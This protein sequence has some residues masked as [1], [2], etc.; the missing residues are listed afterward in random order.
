MSKSLDRE[1]RILIIAGKT[2]ATSLEALLR[3]AGWVRLQSV[4]DSARAAQAFREDQPDLVLIQY[5]LGQLD[6]VGVMRQLRALATPEELLPFV[7]LTGADGTAQRRAALAAGAEDVLSPPVD[8]GELV[9]RLCG[10]LQLRSHARRARRRVEAA[11]ARAERAD[12]EMARRLALMA[13]YRGT[14]DEAAPASLGMLAATIA[15]ELG[16]PAE[17]VR[18]IRHAAPL[19]DVG[20]IA[21]PH[22]LA[23][24]GLLSLAEL[25]EL[26]THTSIGAQMLSASESPILAMAEEIALFHHENWDGTGY[27]PGLGGESIPLSARIVA[28]A[29]TFDA[30]RRERSYNP[31]HT[32]EETLAWIDSQAGRKFDPAVVEAFRRVRLRAEPLPLL[33]A[34]G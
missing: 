24:Q 2:A 22:I 7:F 27:T 32:E 1:H 3:Q 25:D 14:L 8:A 19:H 23:N 10:L 16:L 17:Q 30:M 20:M 12:V 6:G 11:E 4:A 18:L 34:T 26:K 15:E 21:L 5:E 28:V 33:D 29:D 9:L 13:E 31:A